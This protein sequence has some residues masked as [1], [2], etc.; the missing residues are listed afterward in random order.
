MLS[1]AEHHCLPYILPALLLHVR[2]NVHISHL[3]ACQ[4]HCIAASVCAAPDCVLP[5]QQLQ[6]D[7]A[8]GRLA[9]SGIQVL[10]HTPDA[11]LFCHA[12]ILVCPCSRH[13]EEGVA[14]MILFLS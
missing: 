13:M 11:V 12:V 6:A 2:L 9:V 3:D 8:H 4:V 5:L 10:R 7:D 14:K 1:A